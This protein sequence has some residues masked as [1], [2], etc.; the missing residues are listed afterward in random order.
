[1][2]SKI[3]VSALATCMALGI[4]GGCTP[5]ARDKYDKAGDATA[6][7]V[8]T[9]A[10]KTGEA[11]AEAG[12]KVEDAA[13]SAGTTLKVKNALLTAS[14]LK[15]SDLNVETMGETVTLKGS[16]PTSEQKMQAETIAKGQVGSNYKIDNQLT[17]GPTGA[18]N[19]M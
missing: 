13:D 15:T 18:G 10:A 3:L 16:V 14:D 7:A 5:E 17:V 12:A 6:D 2:N 8:A 19:N 1:M 9:D 11:A 4:L